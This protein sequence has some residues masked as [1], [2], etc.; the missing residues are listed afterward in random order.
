MKKIFFDTEFTGLHQQSTMISLALVAETGE[1]FYAE[2]T[3]YAISQ[4]NEWINKHVVQQLFLN[5]NNCC[6]TFNKYYIKS[7]K[8]TIKQAI[9]TWLQQFGVVK[10]D[11]NNIIPNI[12]IWADVPH[13][14]W[15][16]FCELFGGAFGIP[17]SIHYMPMDLA[18]LLFANNIDINTVRHEMVDT[19]NIPSHIMQHNALYDAHIVKLVIEKI[20]SNGK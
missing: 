6:T 5:E 10:D 12:Q 16:L 15:V 7:D 3:D 18:T 14:D 8:N 9:E 13:W 2:F 19:S 20:L 17:K 1:E 4:T 11:K